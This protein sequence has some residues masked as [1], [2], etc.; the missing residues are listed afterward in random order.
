MSTLQK[1]NLLIFNKISLCILKNVGKSSNC[2]FN[3]SKNILKSAWNLTW[4]TS[5]I[6]FPG[7]QYFFS[8]ISLL[9]L[10]FLKVF[11]R[12]NIVCKFYLHIYSIL[13]KGILIIYILTIYDNLNFLK[14][15]WN[16]VQYIHII[17]LLLK[18]LYL[19]R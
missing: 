8:Y 17:V 9:N 18:N 12:N 15:C 5:K 6:F 7:T 16:S 4:V 10:L 2:Y 19:L 3:R 1:T 11:F 14:Y 13:T